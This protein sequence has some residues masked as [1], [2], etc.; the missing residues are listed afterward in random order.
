MKTRI[1][2][3]TLVPLLAVA[4]LSACTPQVAEYS[5]TE[6]SNDIKVTQLGLVHEV[7]FP[8]GQ[9]QLGSA[10]A[11]KLRD[12]VQ[13]DQ[14]GYG[15]RV[16]LPGARGSTPEAT[17]LAQRQSD[18]VAAY[19]RRMGLTVTRQPPPT[20]AT[21][22]TN[23][24]TVVVSRA[25]ATPPNCANWSKPPGFDATNSTGA[26]FGCATAYNFAVM[27]ADPNDLLVGRTPGP[28]D[29]EQQGASIN[30]YRSGKIIPLQ[31]QTTR[32]SATGAAPE[33]Q[34]GGTAG[35]S[36]PQ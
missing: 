15:D 27:V 24:I 22:P 30:R 3:R 2:A 14:V 36:A 12:F 29:A 11:Q 25:V 5:P 19:L 16:I 17:L 35:V 32:G 6:A 23:Q 1:V 18:A 9:S 8:A 13:R 7:R 21:A 33:A 31:S 4:A 34:S 26:N 28:A 20:V 10:E